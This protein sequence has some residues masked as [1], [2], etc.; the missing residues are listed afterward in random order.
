LHG[1][2]EPDKHLDEMIA[3]PKKLLRVRP[4]AAELQIS[5]RSFHELLK[6]GMPHIRRRKL[7][8]IDPEAAYRWLGQF[9]RRRTK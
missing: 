6:A 5:I 9:E 1:A 4:M 8:W 3:P 7:I 2:T